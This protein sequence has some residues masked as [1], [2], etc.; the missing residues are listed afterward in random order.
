LA[1][2]TTS[3]VDYFGSFRVQA[4]EIGARLVY[5]ELTQGVTIRLVHLAIDPAGLPDYF[6]AQ[7]M[8][9]R[10]GNIPARTC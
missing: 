8:G 7:Y 2:G 9:P 4:G 3:R 6:Q 5:G 10:Y 1:A